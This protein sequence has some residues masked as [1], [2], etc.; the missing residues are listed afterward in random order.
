MEG[1]SAPSVIIINVHIMNKK[2]VY[3]ISTY[4]IALLLLIGT[5]TA[6]V[7][8]QTYDPTLTTPT[9]T[10][11]TSTIGAPTTGAGGNA[12]TNMILFASS[13]LLI[14]G[15]ALFIRSAQKTQI[16]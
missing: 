7:S 3:F 11:A 1:A 13:A 4:V 5:S 6:T 10:Q 8:A 14:L 2:I 9:I 15:G 12:S 16:K